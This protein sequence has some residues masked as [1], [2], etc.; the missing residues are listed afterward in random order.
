M[1]CRVVTRDG[2]SPD[3]CARHNRPRT[4]LPAGHDPAGVLEVEFVQVAEVSGLL[5]DH[6]IV[7]V[8][9]TEDLSRL[10]M[11]N[12]DGV[13]RLQVQSEGAQS[14]GIEGAELLKVGSD[15]LADCVERVFHRLHLY[16][17]VLIPVSKWR[18]V[19][20]AVAFSMAS[21]EDWQ[22]FDHSATVELNTRDPLFCEPADF[23]LLSALVQSLLS[24][25]ED[26][27]HG[28]A[29]VATGAPVMAEV[30]PPGTIVVSTGNQMLADSIREAYAG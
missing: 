8:S 17:L 7:E 4:L 20:D 19:F 3:R 16:E 28:M 25:G 1:L 2:Q 21:N 26:A 29:I 6:G 9:E 5:R 14:V 11:E 23:Q 27:D 18:A 30:L 22:E 10:H 24:D 13:S 15:V 12:P